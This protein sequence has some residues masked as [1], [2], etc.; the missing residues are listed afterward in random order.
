M[1]MSKVGNSSAVID[2]HKSWISP[3]RL[4]LHK[5]AQRMSAYPTSP[6]N[7][8][9]CFNLVLCLNATNEARNVGSARCNHLDSRG[10]TIPNAYGHGTTE[11]RRRMAANGGR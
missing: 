11:E 1:N 5:N 2:P 10:C 6:P 8:W 9:T 3:N 4:V 7:A